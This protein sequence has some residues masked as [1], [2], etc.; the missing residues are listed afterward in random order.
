[1]KENCKSPLFVKGTPMTL[2]VKSDINYKICKDGDGCPSG[3]SGPIVHIASAIS[4]T[5]L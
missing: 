2:I 3:L 1:M 4:M 5:R